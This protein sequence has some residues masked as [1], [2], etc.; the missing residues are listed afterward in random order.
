M[1]EE[2]LREEFKMFLGPISG[3]Q[4]QKVPDPW[5]LELFVE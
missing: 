2:R 4:Q 3:F 5:L 1:D